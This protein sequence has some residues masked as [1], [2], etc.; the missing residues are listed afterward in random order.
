MGGVLVSDLET[1]RPLA[2]AIARDYFLP[3]ADVDDVRQEA[4]IGVWKALRDYRP[5][6]GTTL[7]SFVAICVRRQCISAVKT[8]TRAKHEVLNRAV[9]A[10]RPVAGEEDE[11]TQLD[12]L[13]APGADPARIVEDREQLA[14][15]LDVVAHDLS[16]LERRALIG[17]ANGLSY[18]ELREDA[19]ELRSRSGGP[20]TSVAPKS[21]DNA[22][23]RARR[24]LADPPTAAAL[25][26]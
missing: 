14:E 21:I 15:L 3:G 26:A 6:A 17:L 4:M 23:Q 25:A 19:S 24:K 7:R 20:S 1:F 11:L 5:D 13:V 12:M 8:A 2:Y 18:E 16:P 9:Y 22:L 10:D